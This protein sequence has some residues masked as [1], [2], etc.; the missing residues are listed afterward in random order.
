MQSAFDNYVTMSATLSNVAGL[1]KAVEKFYSLLGVQLTTSNN[2]NNQQQ[3]K[4]LFKAIADISEEKCLPT[5]L[6]N[7]MKMMFKFYDKDGDGKLSKP[8]LI[9]ATNDY[10]V[11]VGTENNAAK[12][13]ELVQE[14]FSQQEN[15]SFEEFYE[16]STQ[17]WLS[18]SFLLHYKNFLTFSFHFL[19]KQTRIIFLTLTCNAFVEQAQQCHLLPC[20]LCLMPT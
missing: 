4:N 6:V 15:F 11:L 9:T 1:R 8:E 18:C 17:V 5:L 16:I 3:H 14:F 10:L 12:A 19:K 2:N 7:I 13:A 20:L